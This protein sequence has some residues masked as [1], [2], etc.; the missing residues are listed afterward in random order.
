MRTPRHGRVY[1]A[2]A[3][4]LALCMPANAQRQERP[5]SIGPSVRLAIIVEDPR[6]STEADLLTVELSKRTDIELLERAQINK[7]RGEQA[8]TA[9]QRG[10]YLKLGE[11][12]GAD[13]VL[14]LGLL[15]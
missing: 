11:L 9:S 1:A 6:L 7:V 8:L 2:I 15:E 4:L 14:I 10:D 13:G 12:L 3:L 5:T